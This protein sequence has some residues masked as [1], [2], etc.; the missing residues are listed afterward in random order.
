MQQLKTK[1]KNGV[2]VMLLLLQRYTMIKQL[3]EERVYLGSAY[4]FRASVHDHHTG[5]RAAGRHGPGAV[6][7]IRSIS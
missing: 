4:S 6:A 5:S 3:R 2:L 1:Y 7:Y